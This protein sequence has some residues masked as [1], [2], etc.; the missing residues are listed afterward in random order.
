[1]LGRTTGEQGLSVGG[2]HHMADCRIPVLL[3]DRRLELQ[4]QVPVHTELLALSEERPLSLPA[5]RIPEGYTLGFAR[6][7]GQEPALRAVRERKAKQSLV[8][9]VRAP[10]LTQQ[11]CQEVAAIAIFEVR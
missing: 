6:S 3:S 11:V 5:Q 10:S 9:G 4:C 1:M 8:P 7:R 2:K